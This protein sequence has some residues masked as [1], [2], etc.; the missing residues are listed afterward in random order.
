VLQGEIGEFIAIARQGRS[1]EHWYVG[2][3]TNE[4]A[5]SLRLNLSFLEEG[6]AYRAEI[7]ADAKDAHYDL[8]PTATKISTEK[9]TRDRDLN[10]DLAPG[11]GVAIVFKKL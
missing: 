2:C 7:Y 11:G 4:Q 10:L 5:R 3:S 9:V 6:Q 8:N 1:T